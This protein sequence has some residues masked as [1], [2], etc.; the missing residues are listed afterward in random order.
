MGG[1]DGATWQALGLILTLVGLGLSAVV[2]TRRGPAKGL[3]GVAWS[4]VPLA[5]GL[6]GLLRLGWEIT[7]SVLEWAARLVFSPVVWLGLVVA[8]TSLVL[9]VVSGWLLRRGGARAESPARAAQ[10]AG[11]HGPALTSTGRPPAG[12]SAKGSTAK[13][14]APK[15]SAAKGTGS[16]GDDMAEIEEILRKHGIQ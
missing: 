11:P 9:F 5:A 1:F 2:W 6:T 15:G 7:D 8:A 13:G 12:S 16:A 10:A 4:L 14:T 3:R